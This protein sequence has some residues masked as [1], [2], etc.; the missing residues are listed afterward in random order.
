MNPS[1]CEP[2]SFRQPLLPGYSARLA[3]P[4]DPAEW[5][6]NLDPDL[7]P[8]PDP[9]IPS[10]RPR[11]GCHFCITANTISSYS[12]TADYCSRATLPAAPCGHPLTSC[13]FCSSHS[14][15]NWLRFRSSAPAV[16]GLNCLRFRALLQFQIGFV[17]R[18][19]WHVHA[20][21]GAPL[22][23]IAIARSVC[24]VR[25]RRVSTCGVRPIF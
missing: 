2:S 11:I 10:H 25:S 20:A 13:H 23:A 8:D 22:D 14:V 4:S 6:L 24:R 19:F 15:S 21:G 9:K 16:S 17:W 5:L 3:R 1:L 12:L 7:N 18:F